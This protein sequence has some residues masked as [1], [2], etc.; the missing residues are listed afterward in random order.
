MSRRIGVLLAVVG[1]IAILTLA[2]QPLAAAA[3]AAPRVESVACSV[4]ATI[5][6]THFAFKP[7]TVVAGDAATAYLVAQNCTNKRQKT[8]TTWIAQWINSSVSPGTGCPVIDPFGGSADFKPFGTYKTK[9]S[10]DIPADCTAAGL[11]VTVKISEGATVLAQGVARV[12]IAHA[13]P[14]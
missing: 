12:K 10:Y 11:Q 13:K 6:I 1:P 7:S 5:E 9:V 4:S 2:N 8:S 3:G 14:A